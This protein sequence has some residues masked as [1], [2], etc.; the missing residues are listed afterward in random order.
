MNLAR[1]GLV[2][3]EQ[4]EMVTDGT[5][6]LVEV[7]RHEAEADSSK[8]HKVESFEE[9]IDLARAL[10]V[11]V[12]E[13]D[14]A[15]P[16]LFSRARRG[17]RGKKTSDLPQKPKKT[18][19]YVKHEK[20]TSKKFVAR[21]MKKHGLV[22]L[23]TSILKMDAKALLKHFAKKNDAKEIDKD[24]FARNVVWEFYREIQ[25]GRPPSFVKDG[26]NIRTIFYT[27]KVVFAKIDKIFS[28]V[29]SIYGNFTQAF[30][31]LVVAGLI[32]YKDFNIM[33][34]R[35]AFRLLPPPYGNPGV[36]LLAEKKAFVGR[37]FSLANRYGVGAQITNGR[38]TTLMTD[39]LLTEMFES[40][41]DLSHR[42]SILSFCDFDP[43]GTSIPYHFVK[44]LKLL[45]FY[46]VNEFTQYGDATMRRRVDSSGN[47]PRYVTVRQRRPCLDIVNPHDLDS[48]I[49][50]K[51][52]HKLKASLRDNP[53]TAD[54]A[55]ITGGVTGTGR[56][57]S[58]AISSEQFLP[59]LE[60]HLEKKI[61]PLLKKPPEEFARQLSYKNI[62]QAIREYIG[63]RAERDA[64][65]SD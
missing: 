64:Q 49:R 26:C 8:T 44:H 52:R 56:N 51:L 41:Y 4:G 9:F 30:K 55:F 45:G 19:K 63:A 42:L 22:D 6:E 59:Y 47:R 37:F 27:L 60:E 24:L 40:G 10:G 15:V 20:K 23:D 25:A 7:S 36:L 32:S 12:R 5:P 48:K 65:N 31:T 2:K 34:D 21:M 16:L 62:H 53:T 38:S 28:N 39:T 33:D 29:N 3:N 61:R 54:W 58:Y 14:N 18:K 50:N 1:F 17:R 11:G 57:K 46:N 35:A 13:D 43:V